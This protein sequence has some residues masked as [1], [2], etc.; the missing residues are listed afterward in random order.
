QDDFFLD[1]RCPSFALLSHRVPPVCLTLLSVRRFLEG[2]PGALPNVPFYANRPKP[3]L[4]SDPDFI[5]EALVESGSAFLLD[6]AHARVAAHHRQ[7][8]INEYLSDLPLELV[9]EIHISGPRMEEAGLMDRH[10]TL[11]DDDWNLL[12]WTLERTSSAEILTHEYLGLRPKTLQ[13]ADAHG[14]APLLS[15]IRKMDA[16]R[17][18]ILEGQ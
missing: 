9:K 15:E 11:Q 6:L 16:L 4:N 3:R 13:Y 17:C 8:D 14:P 7:E 18:Q 12:R 5:R 2:I 1:P 10:L